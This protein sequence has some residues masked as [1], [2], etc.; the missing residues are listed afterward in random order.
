MEIVHHPLLS[1]SLGTERELVSLHFGTR[2]ASPKVYIQ[3]S[4]HADELPG[5]LVAW[6]LRV[7]LKNLESQGR[8]L[9]EIILVPVANPIGLSQHV[10]AN[11]L[12]R[13]DLATSQNFNNHFLDFAPKI[14]DALESLLT[15]NADE[16]KAIIRAAM[17]EVLT[18]EK[19]KTELE[20]LRLLIT[21]LSFDA[22]VVLDLHCDWEAVPHLYAGTPLWEKV[23]PLARYFGAQTVLLSLK[24]GDNPFDDAS[25][26]TW[27]KLR[28]HFKGEF[29]IP[30]GCVAVTMEHRG[31][32]DVSH[33]L[34]DQ[35][36]MAIM[37]YLAHE[38]V[39]D[40]RV[41]ELPAL[42]Y[43]A[44]ELARVE[45]MKTPTSGVIVYRTDL[46]EFVTKGTAI[47]DIVDPISGSAT[48]IP[49]K[50]TFGSSRRPIPT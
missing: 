9:G 8:I 47:A 19:P 41:P 5:M 4:L 48:T 46:G 6:F 12:G 13:Y 28:E 17:A 37:H 39:V 16:N 22:D 35:D 45:Y 29:P 23:E 10:M 20:S 14:Q 40:M 7:A 26:Q 15:E 36:A 25:G 31:Q 44:T 38:G 32:R 11:H 2:G 18:K 30:H 3:A 43:P 33:E 49:S 42:P 1:H 34:A 24:S 27:W 21:K 50:S